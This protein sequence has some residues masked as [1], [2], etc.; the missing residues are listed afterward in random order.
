VASNSSV[1]LNNYL[2][3]KK[4]KSEKRGEKNRV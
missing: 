3:R 4:K 1:F 2:W